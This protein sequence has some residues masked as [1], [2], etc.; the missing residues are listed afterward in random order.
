MNGFMYFLPGR[1]GAN[2]GTIEE[3]GLGG[4]LGNQVKFVPAVGPT[5]SPG[6]FA[7]L[8]KVEVRGYDPKAQSWQETN[9]GYWV[10]MQNDKRPG[11]DDLIRDT[12]YNSHSVE[13]GDGK[14]W[15]FPILRVAM[16]GEIMP[17]NRAFT[18]DA[19]GDVVATLQDE[20]LDLGERVMGIAQQYFNRIGAAEIEGEEALNVTISIAD[21][22]AI[23]TD[24][25][26]INYRVTK[27]ECSLLKLFNPMA[28]HNSIQAILDVPSMFDLLKKNFQS[29]ASNLTDGKDN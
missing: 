26:R 13:L 15:R 3:L 18:L 20:F 12:V 6:M 17:I 16:T 24:A 22:F 4:R 29:D 25:L 10:G 19:N 8:D 27:W 11:P 28:I 1:S 2:S 9:E 21:D 7:A 14:K 5:Q 23:L